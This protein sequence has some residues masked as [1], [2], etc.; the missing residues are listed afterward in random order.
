MVTHANVVRFIDV[1]CQRYDLSEQ[2]RFS[3]TFPLVF[4]LAGFDMFMAWEVGGCI[5]CPSPGELVMP[6][7]TSVQRG[8]PCGSPFRH[9]RCT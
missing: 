5:C 6:G 1:M 2:D 9:W 7:R 8:S 3:Q 4:D